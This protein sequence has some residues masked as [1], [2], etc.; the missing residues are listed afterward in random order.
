MS[1]RGLLTILAF[2]IAL[3]SLPHASAAGADFYFNDCDHP[4][5]SKFNV[6]TQGGPDGDDCK[7]DHHKN[8][9]GATTSDA[10]KVPGNS[11]TE[12]ISEDS[13]PVATPFDTEGW[14]GTIYSVGVNP[15]EETYKVHIGFYDPSGDGLVFPVTGTVTF[16]LNNDPIIGT[17][18]DDDPPTSGS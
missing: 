16:D 12:W 4:V 7:P 6:L 15:P 18:T 8:P 10:T 14:E 2:G 17:I 3:A 13:T 9:N 5:Y 1:T 11:C